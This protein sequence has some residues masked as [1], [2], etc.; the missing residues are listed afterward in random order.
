MRSRRTDELSQAYP[1]KNSV[2]GPDPWLLDWMH[3]NRALVERSTG[4]K[5]TQDDDRPYGCGS[6]G[7]VYAT[8]DPKW[9]IKVSSDPSEGP[10]MATV[11][12]LRAEAGGGDGYGPSKILP[13]I[14]FVQQIFQ[15]GPDDDPVFVI[16]R[17]NV[18]P[19][20]SKDVAKLDL[21]YGHRWK[22]REKGGNTALAIA[23]AYAVDFYAKRGEAAVTNAAVKYAEWLDVARDQLPLV[24]EAMM[25]LLRAGI[26]LADVHEWNLGY[27]Q[28]DWGPEFRKP[29]RVIIHDLGLSQTPYRVTIPK[30]NP[31]G[32]TGRDRKRI[33]Q[34]AR[35]RQPDAVEKPWL[36]LDDVARWEAMAALQGVSEAARR[37]DGF[38]GAYKRAKGQK[39]AMP[40][41]W[42]RE[43]ERFI[44]RHVAQARLR[45]E[46]WFVD[47][48]PTRR[49]L[50]LI[51]WAYSP[52]PGELA[53]YAHGYMRN[54]PLGEGEE[55]PSWIRWAIERAE[56]AIARLH[57]RD[58]LPRDWT[59]LGCGVFGCVL[60]AR[61]HGIVCK[62]TLDGSE[63][64]FARAQA[65]LGKYMPGVCRYWEP[66]RVESKVGPIW[67]VWRESID[68]P[69]YAE[70]CTHSPSFRADDGQEGRI[71]MIED[72]E[73]RLA[74]QRRL[75]MARAKWAEQHGTD[76]YEI[77]T[78]LANVGLAVSVR[79]AT[80][81][82][83]IDNRPAAFVRELA[84][85][86]KQAEDL[87]E[88]R[89][90]GAYWAYSR[91]EYASED[92]I[93][94][95]AI[96]LLAY[97]WHL[98]RLA[99]SPTMP[100]LAEALRSYLDDGLLLADVQPDNVARRDGVWTLFDCG[101]TVPVAKRWNDMWLDEKVDPDR[102]WDSERWNRHE[103]LQTMAATPGYMP[104]PQEHDPRKEI[105][106]TVGTALLLTPIDELA[107]VAADTG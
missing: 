36:A 67:I 41:R 62:V 4:L 102:W 13:G 27:A 22:T 93:L 7:C 54:N 43:R 81:S 35:A 68:P 9:V 23:Q 44:A 78:E 82:A 46:P 77:L 56:P 18:R 40:E 106:A 49:H 61:K 97:R 69:S 99:K 103:A 50:A 30:L 89:K 86:Q 88:P 34:L 98:D 58:F 66:V 42:R 17:E 71:W 45:H 11:I 87:F 28:V 32:L 83:N 47:G 96:D 12:G 33:E 19:W 92:R 104:N 31:V 95:A 107:I 6:Y 8:S 72:R 14:V 91:A 26:V 39:H 101:F 51:M 1:L 80:Y 2:E 64:F 10:L 29:G 90:N 52:E 5:I 21:F 74:A 3:F 16:V 65:K 100:Q 25:D 79:F 60:F 37:P 15:T 84:A 70:H 63:A 57:G 76:C 105:A 55:A 20:H 24:A 59:M 85:K 73:K 38:L 75:A 53:R 94:N 48:R